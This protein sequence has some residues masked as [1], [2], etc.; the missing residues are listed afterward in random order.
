MPSEVMTLVIVVLCNSATFVLFSSISRPELINLWWNA[1]DA[2]F[3][4]W[5]DCQC[6][7]SLKQLSC[8]WIFSFLCYFCHCIVCPSSIYG[9]W[10]QFVIFKLVSILFSGVGGCGEIPGQVKWHPSCFVCK[11]KI[12]KG[13]RRTA[14]W[15]RQTDYIHIFL[16][17]RYSVTVNQVMLANVKFSKWWL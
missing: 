2:Y 15:S 8:P 9:F 14:L 3:V 12:M 4:F 16:R 7:S 10:L 13:E 6:V 1:E 17:H 11:L 5:T